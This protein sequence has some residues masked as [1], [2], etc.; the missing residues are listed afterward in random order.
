MKT[1]L[2]K[3]TFHFG[4]IL[5]YH[6][7]SSCQYFTMGDTNQ[8]VLWSSVCKSRFLFTLCFW[9]FKSHFYG[10]GDILWNK[11][12]YSILFE[13]VMLILCGTFL[14]SGSCM[15][16][17][18][19]KLLWGSF[20]EVLYYSWKMNTHVLSFSKDCISLLKIC[21]YEYIVYICLSVCIMECVYM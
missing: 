17:R 7:N 4:G 21:V 2:N 8:E 13:W 12:K 3:P 19:S 1:K 11:K 16:E 20:K 18:M 10:A 14:S 15:S 6:R 9:L 5:L